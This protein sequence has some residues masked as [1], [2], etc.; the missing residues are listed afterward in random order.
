MSEVE[1]RLA[2]LEAKVT[3]LEDIN[4]IRRLQWAYGYYIDYNRPEETAASS[5]RMAASC[6]SRANMSATKA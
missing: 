3:Q 6:S 5:P 2:A 1:S 4:A